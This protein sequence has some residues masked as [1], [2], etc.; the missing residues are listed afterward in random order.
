MV[1]PLAGL[2]TRSGLRETHMRFSEISPRLEEL[3]DE[4]FAHLDTTGDT[5][6]QAVVSFWENMC[7]DAVLCRQ[8]ID[9]GM[10]CFIH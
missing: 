8:L 9:K 5:V 7:C 2:G 6:V 10:P 3:Y 1:N 4:A